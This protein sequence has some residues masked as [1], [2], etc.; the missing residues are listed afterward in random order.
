[1]SENIV[2]LQVK[3]LEFGVDEAIKSLRTNLL[4]SGDIKAIAVT[5][6][7]A[8]EGKSTVAFEI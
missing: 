7:T 3:E 2:S 8:G 5:S 1:M 6:A 4:Y